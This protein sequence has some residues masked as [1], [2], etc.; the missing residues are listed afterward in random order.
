MHWSRFFYVK[1]FGPTVKTMTGDLGNLVLDDVG[2]PGE[3]HV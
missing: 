2:E 1:G 3:V